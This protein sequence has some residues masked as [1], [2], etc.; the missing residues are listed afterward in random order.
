MT[1]ETPHELANRL[2][3]GREEFCQR[4]LTTLILQAPYPRWNT[5]SDPST[6]GLAFLR[7]LWELSGFGGWPG[8]NPWFVDEFELPARADG[9]KGGAPD[10]AV[11]WTDRV[12]MIELKTEGGSHQ[13]AQVPGY[14]ELARHHH[15][16]CDIALTY[17]TPRMEYMFVAPAAWASYAHITWPDV[18]PLIASTWPATDA[19]GQQAVIDGLLD[20]IERMETER[21]SDYLASLRAAATAPEPGPDP[22]ADALTLAEATGDDGQQ[23]ALDYDASSLEE[24]LDLRLQLREELAASSQDSALRCVMPWLWRP[25]SGGAPMTTAGTA[26]GHELRLSR[27]RRPLY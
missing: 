1:F 22:L 20:L 8:G 25:E 13:A 27:Y 14:F 19:P 3:L 4:L 12:W 17:L 11:L 7:H 21:P 26:T 9:E 2:K 24:L 16:E 15:P 10:Y 6:A 23:R 18:A 5:R